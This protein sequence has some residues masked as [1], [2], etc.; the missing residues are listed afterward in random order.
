MTVRRPPAL[1]K[2]ETIGVVATGRWIPPERLDQAREL[3]EGKGYKVKIHPNN[4]ARL[5]EWGGEF[6]ERAN[7]L[8]DY[9]EDPEIN[10]IF[11]ARGGTRTLHL[12]DYLDFDRLNKNPK[13]IMG[14][15][16]NTAI[17]NA[18]YSICNITGVH[19]PHMSGFSTGNAETYYTDTVDLLSS[20]SFSRPFP[21][22]HIL[23]EGSATGP[24]I[25]GNMCIFTYLMGTQFVAPLKGKILFLEDE[26]EEIRNIDRMF[27]QL[28]RLGGL[29]EIAGLMIGGFNMVGNNG[30][31]AFPYTLDELLLEYTHGLDIP[32]ITNAPFGHGNELTPFPIGI[33]AQLTA[34]KDNI[35]VVLLDSAVEK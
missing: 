2:G 9:W 23:R 11:L 15:S 32:V 16:D 27:L 10:A 6:Q 35:R 12:L 8:M 13:I 26:C 3:W 34:Q 4:Y 21:H 17:L 30:A 18:L 7:A 29:N 20:P 14:C 19:G 1:N 24:L 25:G 28:K 22:A 31:I 33:N 5:H